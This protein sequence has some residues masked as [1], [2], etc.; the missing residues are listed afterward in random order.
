MPLLS[1]SRY[2]NVASTLALALAVGG[3]GYAAGALPD[4]GAKPA[5]KTAP[6]VVFQVGKAGHLVKQVH[7]APETKHPI[8]K[9]IS[10]GNYTVKFPG[11]AF[12][13]GA[14]AATCS[15]IDY[16]ADSIEVDGI[17]AGTM[18]VHLFDPA[19]N[20]VNGFF[21]CSVWNLDGK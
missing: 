8:T 17:G 5:D 15:M 19:G 2:A 16:Q 20:P 3:T 18:V 21:N 4:T 6:T 9:R 10:K 12:F 13:S 1:S 11:F 7:I 14:D